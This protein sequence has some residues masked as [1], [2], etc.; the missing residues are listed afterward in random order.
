MTSR[1]AGALAIA[2]LSLLTFAGCVPP[3]PAEAVLA[4]TWRVT[5]ENA[6]DLNQLLIT[7]DQ[8]GNLQTVQYQLTGNA[9]ITVPAPIGDTAVEGNEVTISA[10]F[11]GNT[12]AFTG[13]LNEAQ[14]VATGNVTTLIAVGSSIVSINNGPA[15]LT[16]Q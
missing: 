9:V 15:T 11:N 14:T 2:S 10:T 7:F 12:F 5:A 3:P 4:G 13:T 16:K 8:N 1:T 6:P